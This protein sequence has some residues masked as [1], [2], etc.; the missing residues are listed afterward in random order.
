MP[1]A[2]HS[3]EEVNRTNSVGRS[4]RLADWSTRRRPRRSS[5][6]VMQWNGLTGSPLIEVQTGS[7]VW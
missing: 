1:P 5:A 7:P 2:D 4:H 3:D 6:R